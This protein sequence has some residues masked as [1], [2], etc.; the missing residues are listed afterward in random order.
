MNRY[1]LFLPSHHTYVLFMYLVVLHMHE[2]S[3]DCMGV[4]DKYLVIL[5]TPAAAEKG[6]DGLLC[7]GE[8]EDKIDLRRKHLQKQRSP[9]EKQKTQLHSSSF[10]SAS[11]LSGITGGLFFPCRCC[12]LGFSIMAVL[13]Y[14]LLAYIRAYTVLHNVRIVY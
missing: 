1:E 10:S 4:G 11:F 12:V 5:V 3:F 9:F 14:S 6:R 8:K 7:G 13:F 2:G